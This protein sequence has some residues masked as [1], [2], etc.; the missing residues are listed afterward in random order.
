M[1]RSIANRIP[2]IRTLLRQ[3]ERNRFNRT[4][5]KRNPHNDTVP[6]E[7]MFPLENVHVGRGTY[8]MLNVQSLFVQEGEQLHIGN[9]VSIAPGVQF[10]M[11]VNHQLNT[12]TTFPFYSRL[13][14]R[15]NRDALVRGPIVI[16]DEVWLG[17]NAL[18]MS[19]VRIGKGAIVAAGAIVT[20]DVPPYAIVG[21]NPARLI[22][23]RHNP[24]VVAALMEIDLNRLSDEEIRRHLD[25]IYAPL[26]T[27][28]DVQALQSKFFS[29]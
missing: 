11:G 12:Y 24:E 29:N 20:K 9:F 3:A 19:G 6:G 26:Q 17:T 7:R 8:G 13:V 14:Q 10:L 27:L 28:Q 23:M 2:G 15:S 25:S 18:I 21:G 16:G 1:I 5:R 22:K 4:W